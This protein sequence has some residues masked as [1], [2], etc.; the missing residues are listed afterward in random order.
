MNL[1][2]A[3]AAKKMT[4][5]IKAYFPESETDIVGS[6]L[7]PGTLDICSDVD[8]KI[9]L[10]GNTPVNMKELTE[11]LSGHFCPIFGCEVHHNPC[12]DVL[13]VCFANGWRF[14]LS[15]LYPQAQAAPEA[16]VSFLDRAE[17]TV[18][19]FWFLASMVLV[20]LGRNDFLIAAHLALELCQLHIVLQMLMRDAEKGTGIHRFG[21]GEDVPVLRSLMSRGGCCDVPQNSKDA[22]L[23]I[24]FRV[25]EQMDASSAA[26]LPG[27]V[28]RSET[29]DALCRQMRI[30]R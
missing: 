24:L 15:F 25:A 12:S 14:D 23:D 10:S 6:L 7:A 16:A 17:S 4:D 29:L 21:D 2:H 20:K 13:R 26:V 1:W 11:A 5:F 27:Y 19:G 22:I 9:S 18:H 8:M 28:A 3:E 30:R